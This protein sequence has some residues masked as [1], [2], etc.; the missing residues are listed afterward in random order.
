[1]RSARTR[2]HAHTLTAD[3]SRSRMTSSCHF[4]RR[5]LYRECWT[6][7]RCAHM[8]RR[9]WTTINPTSTHAD[10]LE[11]IGISIA[12]VCQHVLITCTQHSHSVVLCVALECRDDGWCGLCVYAVYC[13]T[14]LRTQHAIDVHNVLCATYREWTQ[15]SGNCG[16]NFISIAG[17]GNQQV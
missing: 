14:L 10:R 9:L 2:K 6:R 13:D 12:R 3:S 16:G 4:G 7:W 8:C 17:A 15:C 1:M 5:R 11:G